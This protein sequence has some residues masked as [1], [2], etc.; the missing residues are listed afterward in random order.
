[1][2]KLYLSLALHN[3]QPVGNYDFVIED[4][5]HKTYEPM[6]TALER[7]PGVRLALH[8]SGPLR[9]WLVAHQ[10][11]FLKRVR[12]LAGRRQ[13]ELMTGGYYEPVLTALPDAD[14]LGQ[15]AKMNEA[16][17][18]DFGVEPIGMWLAERV[19]EP[20]LP[21]ALHEAGIRYTLLDDTHFKY[22]GYTDEDLFGYYVTEE[23]GHPVSVFRV[24]AVSA[25][26]HA[27]EPRERD[28]RVAAPAGRAPRASRRSAARGGDGR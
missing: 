8:Y 7:H 27:V 24:T 2:N 26:C 10:P 18:K 14:K 19:W 28:H 25:L 21:K 17:L 9:D 4:A 13:V 1:M 23:Q 15:I 12:T 20:H 16:V 6:I 5:Y 3:H 22:G 11:D